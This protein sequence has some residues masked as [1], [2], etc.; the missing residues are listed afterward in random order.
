MPTLLDMSK[1]A[2]NWSEEY[3][4]IYKRLPRVP[5]VYKL[6]DLNGE[7]ITGVF[8]EPQLQKI[9]PPEFHIVEKVLKKRG[10]KVLVRWR[11]F[12]KSFES[13]ISVNDIKKL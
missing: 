8:Y 3:F 6:K 13:Y 5:S 12:P 2:D 11:G 7:D 9:T 4:V 1:L 10:N